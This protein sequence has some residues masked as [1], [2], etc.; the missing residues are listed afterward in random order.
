MG[1]TLTLNR[2]R[3]IGSEGLSKKDILFFYREDVT[4]V[5][6]RNTHRN[7]HLSLQGIRHLSCDKDSQTKDMG[8]TKE[9]T[10]LTERVLVFTMALP[11]RS[12]SLRSVGSVFKGEGGWLEMNHC[13]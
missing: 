8:E 4:T 7:H 13:F 11:T 12:A 6:Q 10:E 2:L 3:R 5:T 1:D 9:D